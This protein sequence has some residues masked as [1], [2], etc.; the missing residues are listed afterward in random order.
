MKLRPFVGT[1]IAAAL[2]LSACG[3]GGRPNDGSVAIGVY[4]ASALSLPVYVAV[5]QGMFDKEG[6][7][8]ELIDG[9]NGPELISGLI[10]GTTDLAVGAPGTVV[11]AIEQGQS[12]RPLSPYGSIDLAIAVTKDSGITTI[13]DLPGKRIAIPS[14]GGA[15]EQFVNQLLAERNIDASTVQFIAAAPTASQIPLARKGDIDAAVLTAA[16]QAVFDA[17]GIPMTAI[18]E[19][20]P[21][22][23]DGVSSYGLGTVLVTTATFAESDA[24]APVCAALE[25][26]A[27]WIADPADVQC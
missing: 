19:V 11:P 26:A 7:H 4:P 12:L 17:Q 14:R 25:A 2:L 23:S 6:L 13:E 20:D 8:V 16:S 9:K 10:G 21:V 1:V 22:G 27:G 5:Q 24:A 18:T 15:A 3:G